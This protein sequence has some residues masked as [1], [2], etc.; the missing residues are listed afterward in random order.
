MCTQLERGQPSPAPPCSHSG[1]PFPVCP[2]S[3]SGVGW[4]LSRQQ[5]GAP[6]WRPSGEGVT[7]LRPLLEATQRAEAEGNQP[8]FSSRADHWPLALQWNCGD[9]L[10]CGTCLAS[11]ACCLGLSSEMGT[12]SLES[13]RFQYQ[14]G[15]WGRGLASHLIRR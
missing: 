2:Q 9:I 4:G 14:N 13:V 10:F 15:A 6:A 1:G 11:M 5:S 12:K 3:C 7:V 8:C